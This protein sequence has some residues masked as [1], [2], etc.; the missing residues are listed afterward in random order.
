LNPIIFH[1]IYVNQ[2]E[3]WS[4]AWVLRIWFQV[5]RR[6]T[7]FYSSWRLAHW[8][9]SL[10]ISSREGGS[11]WSGS[12][13]WDSG[14][15]KIAKYFLTGPEVQ[16]W[17]NYSSQ[18]FSRISERRNKKKG[19]DITLRYSSLGS[20]IRISMFFPIIFLMTFQSTRE[21]ITNDIMD[22]DL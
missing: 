2:G 16:L 14:D 1:F 10:I 4:H 8:R 18:D 15:S 9:R 11:F 13:D 22:T 7:S 21:L 5:S 12:D 17:I 6:V 20:D 3:F 19:Y